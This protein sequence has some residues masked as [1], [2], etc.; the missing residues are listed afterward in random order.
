MCPSMKLPDFGPEIE[1]GRVRLSFTRNR[2]SSVRLWTSGCRPEGDQ[3]DHDDERQQ[4]G[5]L[6]GSD[7]G[8]PLEESDDGTCNGADHRC[9]SAGVGGG[10]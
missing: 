4:Q 9:L 6:Y 2:H 10:P 8:F 3:T 5:A 7:A 1:L